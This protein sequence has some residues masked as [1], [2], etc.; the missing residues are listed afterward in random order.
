MINMLLL[1]LSKEYNVFYMEK[2][3]Y[4]E[5]KIFKSFFVKIGNSKEEFKNKRSLLMYLSKF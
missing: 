5:D 1:K 2:R 3:N 4:K